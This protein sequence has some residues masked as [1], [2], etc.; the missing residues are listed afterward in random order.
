MVGY[1]SKEVVVVDEVVLGLA[2]GS[3]ATAGYSCNVR[4]LR[5]HGRCGRYAC[6]R[7]ACLRYACLRY[8]CLRYACLVCMS[9]A[10]VCM[11][12]GH[13]CAWA[14]AC[15]GMGV[16]AWECIFVARASR[17][18]QGTAPPPPPLPIAAS[19]VS[20]PLYTSTS[21]ARCVRLYTLQPT[22]APTC[23]PNPSSVARRWW[24]GARS[25]RRRRCSPKA[26]TPKAWTGDSKAATVLLQ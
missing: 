26:S 1:P 21:L 2:P 15:L 25:A 17:Y 20:L 24:A 4:P 12:H 19:P 5:M 6:L 7:Y 3:A 10:L 18:N 11:W 9:C 13:G 22:H 23:P 16:H 8:A 14:G